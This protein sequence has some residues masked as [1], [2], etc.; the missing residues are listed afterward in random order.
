M[1]AAADDGI[2]RFAIRP[3]EHQVDGRRVSS[4]YRTE[5]SRGGELA[6]VCGAR[7]L[8]GAGYKSEPE[9]EKS[10]RS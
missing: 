9:R 5:R 10:E 3:R 6:H 8:E 2:E 4:D 7:R 1:V